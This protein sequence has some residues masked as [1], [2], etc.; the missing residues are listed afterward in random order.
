MKKI[1]C[2]LLA[3][4]LTFALLPGWEALAVGPVTY[5][6]SVSGSDA[7]DGLSPAAP[8]RT[9]QAGIDAAADGNTVEVAAGVYEENIVIDKAVTLRGPNAGKA[10]YASNRVAEAVIKNV[11]PMADNAINVSISAQNVVV[12]GFTIEGGE[13]GYRGILCSNAYNTPTDINVTVQNNRVVKF[14]WYD[15]EG[16][17]GRGIA[18]DNASGTSYVYG[19]KIK[20][21]FVQ[22]AYGGIV[23]GVNAYADVADNRIESCFYGIHYVS[24]NKPIDPSLMNDYTVHD[25]RIII[26]NDFGWN[27]NTGFEIITESFKTGC[28]GIYFNII[29][30]DAV[31]IAKNNQIS[32]SGDT[33]LIHAGINVNSLNNGYVRL[34]DNTISG[35]GSGIRVWGTQAS[36]HDT[37]TNPL[38]SQNLQILGGTISGGKYGINITDWYWLP[39][40]DDTAADPTGMIGTQNRVFLAGNLQVTSPTKVRIFNDPVDTRKVTI[41]LGEL[42]TNIDFDSDTDVVKINKDAPSPDMIL[43][44]KYSAR[45]GDT[46]YQTLQQALDAAN[47][48]SGDTNVDFFGDLE[49]NTD[50]EI[51]SNV[52]LTV[53]PVGSLNIASG[54]TL[55]NNGTLVNNGTITSEGSIDNPGIFSRTITYVGNGSTGGLIPAGETKNYNEPFTVAP[56]GTLIKKGSSFKGWNTSADGS[57]TTYLP[58]DIIT[59]L[60]NNITLYAQW[61]R[62]AEPTY[63]V[64]YHPNGG[65]G[66]VPVDMNRYFRGDK[67]TLASGAGLT[68]PGAVFL[69]WA[70]ADGTPVTG[71]YTMG[72]SDVTFF[73]VWGSVKDLP[74][75]PKTGDNAPVFGFIMLFSG[76]AAAAVILIKKRASVK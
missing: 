52:T 64:S 71:Q 67:V 35:V 11:K 38:L 24:F 34:I 66:A 1:T 69:G 33:Q 20:N 51:G 46:Y 31:G 58:G 29:G 47:A 62:Q 60:L 5:Y 50:T 43:I 49:L 41:Q 18:F 54:V 7:N 25:N 36:G 13:T 53:T 19:I 28:T 26:D 55:T 14:G 6:V 44:L 61:S 74:H 48:S 22:Y 73:A 12:D 16:P 40:L 17:Y 2:L 59:D 56:E 75:V 68:K 23:L 72:S 45:I 4:V 70:L 21:N 9:I 63:T 15:A 65:K 57:G 30:S 76:L 42:D 27:E 3:I 8:K 10:G 37:S 32:A 39:G